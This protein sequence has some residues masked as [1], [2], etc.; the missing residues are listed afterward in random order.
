MEMQKSKG[1]KNTTQTKSPK[2]RKTETNNK[3]RIKGNIESE[4]MQKKKRRRRK[5]KERDTHL[6]WRNG[7]NTAQGDLEK[8]ESLKRTLRVSLENFL[9]LLSE[10]WKKKIKEE[11]F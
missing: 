10:K 1:Q 5:W 11:K 2:R 4:I 3:R 7:K 8:K 6:Q 9:S